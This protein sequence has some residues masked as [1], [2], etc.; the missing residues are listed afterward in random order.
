[1]QTKSMAATNPMSDMPMPTINP[2]I[3]DS[4]TVMVCSQEIDVMRMA[5]IVMNLSWIMLS[6]NVI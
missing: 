5:M 1:M 3:H 6:D 2:K 4:S